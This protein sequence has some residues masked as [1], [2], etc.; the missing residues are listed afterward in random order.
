VTDAAGSGDGVM[1]GTA[2]PDPDAQWVRRALAGDRGAFEHLVLNHQ[3]RVFNVSCRMLGD[4][5]E[6]LDLA[7]EVFLQAHRAL[8][9]FRGEAH[10]GSWLLAITVNQCRNRLKLWKRRARSGHESLSA[11]S[12]EE[13]ANVR[14]ELADTGA[15]AAEALEGRQLE[16]LVGEELARVDEEFRTVLVLRELQGVAYEEIARLLGVPVGT[17]KSRLHRGRAELRDRVRRRLAAPA[18]GGERTP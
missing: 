10:F 7:Q 3:R 16:A 8:G 6:A 12:G 9:Q 11:P 1:D 4:R 17:V 15:T 2:G 14:R 5:D 13:G 18:G